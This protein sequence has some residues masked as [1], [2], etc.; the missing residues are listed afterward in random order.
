MKMIRLINPAVSIRM[1]EEILTE[2]MLISSITAKA[3]NMNAR[4]LGFF[5][6][7]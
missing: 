2:K 1:I 7:F 4:G 3:E 6:I 5:R